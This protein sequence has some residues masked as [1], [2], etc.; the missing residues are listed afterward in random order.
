MSVISVLNQKGGAGKTTV[1]QNVAVELTRRG[2]TVFV[3]DT[4][5]Q[6]TISDWRNLRKSEDVPVSSI[7]RAATLQA[8]VKT[9]SRSF[10]VIVI[11]GASGVNEVTAAAVKVSDAVII[12]V[13]P[14]PKDIWGTSDLVDLIQTRHVV[15]DGVPKAAFLVTRAK[16]NTKLADQM[17]STLAGLRLPMFET[18]IYDREIYKQVDVTGSSVIE[19]GPNTKAAKEIVRLVDELLENSFVRKK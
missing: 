1:A 9:H 6:G 15:S 11:D 17:E 3:I 10:D 4:D 18:Y 16:E 7:T 2:M 8:D 13:Q 5:P 14:S 12:P 19:Q